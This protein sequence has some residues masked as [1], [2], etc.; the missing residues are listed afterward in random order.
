MNIHL[1]LFSTYRDIVGVGEMDI[2][3]TQGSCLRDLLDVLTS[4]YPELKSLERKVLL[5]VNREFAALDA[6]LS[7]GDE[8]A[9]MPPIGGG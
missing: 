6:V 8:V 3:L 5:A 4:K 2:K 9:L 1:R 7:Q